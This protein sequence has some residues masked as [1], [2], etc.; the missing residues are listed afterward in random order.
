MWHPPENEDCRRLLRLGTLGYP[1]DPTV[2]AGKGKAGK[3]AS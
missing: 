3:A 1:R 2:T